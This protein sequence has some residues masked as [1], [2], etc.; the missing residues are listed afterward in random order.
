[1]RILRHR[2]LHPTISLR[3]N[4]G[5][6]KHGPVSNVWRPDAARAAAEGFNEM[7]IKILVR[8]FIF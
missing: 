5:A 3:N 7:E 1:M 2:V 8:A 4:T 6:E